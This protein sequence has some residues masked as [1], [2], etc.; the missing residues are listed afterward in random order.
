[1]FYRFL[2]YNEITIALPITS[3]LYIELSLVVGRLVVAA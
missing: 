1:M 3:L 2:V